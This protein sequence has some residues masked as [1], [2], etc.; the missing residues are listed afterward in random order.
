MDA[1][2]WAARRLSSTLRARTSRRSCHVSDLTG[3]TD[4]RTRQE[5]MGQ[6]G[7]QGGPRN[8]QVAGLYVD[9]LGE[10]EMLARTLFDEL[11]APNGPVRLISTEY[12]L[13]E[14]VLISVYPQL[15]EPA[16]LCARKLIAVALAGHVEM[17]W[18]EAGR[19]AERP[20]FRILAELKQL[21]N[22]V[23]HELQK[24]SPYDS[25]GPAH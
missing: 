20:E 10:I 15:H 19:F 2:S 14:R 16:R 5:L 18:A 13:V 24:T 6:L 22:E 11:Q 8:W 3:P 17:D 1:S 23:A 12:L 9:I 4:V 21:V 7:A 25:Q